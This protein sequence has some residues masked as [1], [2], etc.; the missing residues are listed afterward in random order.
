[1]KLKQGDVAPLF[2]LQSTSG[3]EV[4]L[5]SLRGSKVLLYFYPKDD[6]PGCTIE[7]CEFRDLNEK[8]KK[9]GVIIF[10]ISADNIKSHEKF[11]TKFS[12]NFHL[13][14]DKDKEISR[15]YDVLIKKKMYGREYM[16]I[17]RISFLID[18]E[19]KIEKI[20]NPV[21]PNGH[22]QEVLDLVIK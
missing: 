4:D 20:W 13:Q 18:E 10:G 8:L 6:T 2:S 5:I 17:G 7:A 1:M 3:K 15:T 21:D 16:G 11:R 14:F 12:L 22:A 9:A 19:G